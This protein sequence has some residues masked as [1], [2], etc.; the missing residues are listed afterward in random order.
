VVSGASG[1]KPLLAGCWAAGKLKSVIRD[2]VDAKG[3]IL[4]RGKKRRYPI[5]NSPWTMAH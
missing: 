1:R 5:L 4:R 2:I 3:A